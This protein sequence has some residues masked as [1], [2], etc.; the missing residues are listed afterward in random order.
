MSIRRQ[1]AIGISLLMIVIMG[2]NLV[3]NILQ[4]RS[5]LEK[6]LDVRADETVTTL[7][8]S[9]THNAALKD[10]A[11]LRSMVDV[12]FD[13][14]HFLQVRFDYVDHQDSVERLASDSISS[15]A[16]QWFK[17]LLPLYSG[18]AEAFVTQGWQQLGLL[19]VHMHKGVSYQQLWT[20]VKAE[21][22]WFILMTFILIYGLRVMLTWHLNPLKEVISMAEKLANNQFLHITRDPKSKE[23]KS[24]VRAMNQ[25]S[26][27]LQASFLAHGDTVKRLQRD[28][29]F[30]GLTELHNRRGW[31]QFLEQ[32]MTPDGFSSGWMLLV[33]IENLTALN[34]Q[35]GRNQVDEVLMQMALQLKSSA[36][37]QKESVCTARLGG[38]FWVFCPDPLDHPYRKRIEEFASS[39]KQLSQIQ[40]YGVELRMAALPL[41]DSI[42]PASV[43]HQLDLLVSQQGQNKR[44]DV[45]IGR[46]DDHTV[47]NWVHWQQK[48]TS[49]LE[50]DA[51][52]LYGQDCENS[53]GEVFQTEIHCRLDTGEDTPLLAGYF[54]PMV[55]RLNLAAKFDR[56]VLEKWL[57]LRVSRAQQDWVINLSHNSLVDDG[58]RQWFMECIPQSANE[59]LIIECS[60]YTLAHLEDKVVH[61]LHNFVENGGRLAVDRVGTSGKSFGF[62]ARFPIY[63]GKIEKRFIHNIHQQEDHAF[64]VSAMVQVFHAQNALCLVEGVELKQE[65][66]TLL[67]LGVDGVMGFGVAKPQPL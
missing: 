25:L 10:S 50:Q 15:N 67:D 19:Q 36:F 7:A 62:L 57:E 21:L 30:D 51:L 31:D 46:V 24:L 63:Q 29:Y 16:P 58:F 38:E 18:Y 47:T 11:A 54:W 34:R 12:V 52:R 65:K 17:D 20:L 5:H 44:D 37:L 6:Q 48:L 28:T 9:M 49:C 35:L 40:Q 61:W 4:L 27:R 3:I 55:E 43:K 64:F 2:G 13:R 1:L 32:W 33:R 60:E 14:G 59:C 22:A 8:L 39:L 45:I 53:K 42:A 66:D 23:L 26:D 41:T 56:A